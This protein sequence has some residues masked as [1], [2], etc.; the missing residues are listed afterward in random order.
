MVRLS[1]L[2]IPEIYILRHVCTVLF[3]SMF[4]LVDFEIVVITRYRFSSYHG[5]ESVSPSASAF[6]VFF[7]LA[8]TVLLPF[9]KDIPFYF[10]DTRRLIILVLFECLVHESFSHL[11][12]GGIFFIME[13]VRRREL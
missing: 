11:I 12:N 1:P 9:L 3:V 4:F 10:I 5:A 8:S 2:R 6:L 7:S 13:H